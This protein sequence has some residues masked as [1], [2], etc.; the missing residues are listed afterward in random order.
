MPS[1][2]QHAFQLEERS[3]ENGPCQET[4][5]CK[6]SLICRK[7]W[8]RRAN[9]PLKE[10]NEP[11]QDF[12]ECRSSV[13]SRG[14]C[15]ATFQVPANNGEP[16]LTSLQ[17]RSQVCAQGVCQGSP[18]F[19]AFPGSACSG[20]QDCLSAICDPLLRTCQ[21]GVDFLSCSR[22]GD[23]CDP[24]LSFTCCSRR[25]EKN[26]RSGNYECQGTFS[27]KCALNGDCQDQVGAVCLPSKGECFQDTECC[28]LQCN[29][30]S[31]KPLNAQGQ[32]PCT[33]TSQCPSALR[34]SEK[35]RICTPD[36]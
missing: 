17:C 24:S 7:G 6:G 19:P 30:G 35:L 12:R 18:L 27:R 1:S 36:F 13:C 33:E 22:L 20:S 15:E 9:S 26:L 34:C 16:C 14:F 2:T 31:C 32:I 23:P 25:C 21:P 10:A 4:V 11:C 8:C 29:Q 28:S 3:L 5:Q